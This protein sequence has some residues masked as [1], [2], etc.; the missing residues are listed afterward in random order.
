ML[1]VSHIIALLFPGLKRTSNYAIL[2]TILRILDF[3][4]SVFMV[5][6]HSSSH[7]FNFCSA[8]SSGHVH[9]ASIISQH[10]R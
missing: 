8:N 5:V 9:R 2:S 10:E 6:N 7:S 4:A 3:H 1:K